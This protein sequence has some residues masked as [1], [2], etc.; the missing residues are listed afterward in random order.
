M[1]FSLFFE[2]EV[3]H[4]TAHVIQT[5]SICTITKFNQPVVSYQYQIIQCCP[6]IC[7]LAN[8]I[9]SRFLYQVLSE[10]VWWVF[11][12]RSSRFH[13]VLYL[14]GLQVARLTCLKAFLGTKVNNRFP[15]YSVL[16]F[17]SNRIWH[18]TNCVQ[19][20]ICECTFFNKQFRC[21]LHTFSWCCW[22]RYY[23]NTLDK[24]RS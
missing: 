20:L 12:L 13:Y 22:D 18:M 11:V 9:T 21:F 4:L 6:C 7:S 8:Y 19:R 10:L 15:D 16:Y 17:F 5:A 23:I 14:C 1:T 3:E 24:Q 2:K